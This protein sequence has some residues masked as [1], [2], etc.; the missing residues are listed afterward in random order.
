MSHSS[1]LELTSPKIDSEALVAK[2]LLLIK[3]IFVEYRKLT[4]EEAPKSQAGRMRMIGLDLQLVPMS[5]G[6]PFRFI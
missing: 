2:V 4:N 1:A 5:L 3:N 6:S